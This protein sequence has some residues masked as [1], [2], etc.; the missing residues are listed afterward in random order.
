[1]IGFGPLVS[2]SWLRDHRGEPRLRIIDLRWYMD[3]RPGDE[4]YAAAHI[5]GAAF[6]DLDRDITAA[7][8]PGRHPLPG[9]DQFQGAL[10]KAGVNRGDRVVVYDDAGGFS[11]GR[12]W[13]LLRY[14]GHDE[15]ALLDGGLQAWGEPTESGRQETPAGDFEAGEPQRHWVVD[16]AA[17]AARPPD[18]VL[19]DARAGD[20]YRGEV[21]PLYPRAGHIPGAVNAVWT[22]NLNLD[23]TFKSA[24]ELRRNYVSL[25]VREGRDVVASCGSG[26]SACVDLIGLEVAGIKGA[27]LYEGS[28]GEWSEAA[29]AEVATGPS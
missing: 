4:A 14:F 10:R 18:T 1:M 27:R 24:E 2:A 21:E 26:V 19:L 28:F 16:R 29:D 23:L 25:G 22:D 3:G 5:P 9:R 17:V 12:L 7:K 8:G 20:R 6:I 13:F 11:A 15:V